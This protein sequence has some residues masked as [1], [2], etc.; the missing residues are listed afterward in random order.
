[1]SQSERI[2]PKQ[3]IKQLESMINDLTF[4]VAMSGTNNPLVD[5]AYRLIG[6]PLT[7]TEMRVAIMY[8]HGEY[9]HV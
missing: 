1:M 8:T 7:M 5:K 9:E 6:I 4:E 3:Y 2:N